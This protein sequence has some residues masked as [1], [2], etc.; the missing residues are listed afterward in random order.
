[1]QMGEDSPVS[2]TVRAQPENGRDQTERPALVPITILTG[3]L[4]SGKTTLLNRILS[5][6]H[7]LRVGVLVNDFGAINIDAKLVVGVEGET[8]SL[9]NGCVCCT[10]RDDLVTE[11]QGLLSRPDRP[12]YIVVEASGV[13]D[14]KRIASSFLDSE[15]CA[16]TRVDGIVAMVDA[17]NLP[18]LQGENLALALDQI[19]VA[20]IV[21]LNKAD[22]I[23]AKEVSALRERISELVPKSRLLTAIYGNVPLAL[24]LGVGS[25]ETLPEGGGMHCDHTD[26]S[27]DFQTWSWRTD[28][29]I[30][31]SAFREV[32]G[33]LPESIYR[34]KGILQLQEYPQ[35]RVEFQLTGRRSSLSA[36]GM[37]D[38][39]PH[40]SELVMISSGETTDFDGLAKSL[41]DCTKTHTNADQLVDWR[42]NPRRN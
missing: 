25:F 24:V 13:S 34:S 12:E 11:T 30:S 37:W 27:A 33:S 39:G 31:L 1:M 5:T 6:D 32:I 21:V 8:V 19:S 4:G 28:K 2:T 23:P 20:D 22:L 9:E 41:D 17:A 42:K 14:P 10:I 35:Y 29:P 3:F 16:Q 38:E 36:L 40:T 15:L 26:H 18:T 7:G